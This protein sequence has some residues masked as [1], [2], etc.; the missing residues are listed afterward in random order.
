MLSGE[1]GILLRVASE[2]G[3][4]RVSGKTC[5]RTWESAGVGRMGTCS[6]EVIGDGMGG[7]GKWE[8][9]TEGGRSGGLRDCLWGG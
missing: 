8:S 4:V 3:M 1:N 5:E 6:S 7:E 2:S 9:V